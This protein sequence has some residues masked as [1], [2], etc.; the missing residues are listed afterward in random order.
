MTATLVTDP[1]IDELVQI[2]GTDHVFADRS[3]RVNRAR[4]PAPFPVHRW[5]EHIPDVGMFS[6]ER[7]QHISERLK[8]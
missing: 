4:V 5:A 8:T 6:G 3:A 2:C 1:V 7:S